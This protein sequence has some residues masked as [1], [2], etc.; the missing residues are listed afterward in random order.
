MPQ[1]VAILTAVSAKPNQETQTRKA[2]HTGDR[3]VTGAVHAMCL[4]LY[5]WFEHRAA[6]GMK[7]KVR[8]S[9]RGTD[10]G[11]EPGGHTRGV[12][13]DCN[14]TVCDI[15]AKAPVSRD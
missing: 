4:K 15:T 12:N 2:Y 7:V 6:H 11:V 1:A 8:R 9:D 10:H 3:T 14:T 13:Q 5:A